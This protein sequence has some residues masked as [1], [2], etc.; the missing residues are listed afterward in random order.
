MLA[1]KSLTFSARVYSL[2]VEC[3]SEV[4]DVISRFLS[5]ISLFEP[6]FSEIRQEISNSL[7][8][9]IRTPEMERS[10]QTMCAFNN[11]LQSLFSP[12]KVIIPHIENPQTA[13]RSYSLPTAPKTSIQLKPYKALFYRHL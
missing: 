2:D 12:E 10:L 1:L 13:K 9:E 5:E 8:V 6:D 3:W 11:Y 7:N 4:L